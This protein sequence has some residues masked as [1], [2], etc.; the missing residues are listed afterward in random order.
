MNDSEK[1]ENAPDPKKQ[2]AF[3]LWLEN[4]WYHY[5]W[6]ILLVLFLLIVVI[7]S[8]AQCSSREKYDLVVTLAVGDPLSET[9][10]NAFR[11]TLESVMP[12]DFDG[13][14][15]KTVALTPY[16]IYTE[17]ELRA[18]YTYFDEE[19]QENRVDLST[20]N[21][22]KNYNLDRFE[23]LST[24]LMTGDC[25]VWFVSPYVYEQTGMR[26]LSVSLAEIFGEVPSGAYDDCAIRLADTDLYR[27]YDAV[28]ALPDDT[29]IVLTHVVI[30]E[31]AKESVF[32]DCRAMFE[33]LVGFRKP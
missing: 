21:G 19:K 15:T 13:N 26:H 14:G 22:A 2:S 11:N 24:Y 7:F 23:N 8:V 4:I 28:K 29:L 16:S 17:E 30:G 10:Q 20:Y 6:R 31:T 27:Y 5:K 9:T 1:I 18:M 25:A 12:S 32:A 33:A 3:F